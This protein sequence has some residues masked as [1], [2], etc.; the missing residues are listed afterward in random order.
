MKPGVLADNWIRLWQAPSTGSLAKEAVDTDTGK[1]NVKEKGKKGG[2]RAGARRRM[3]LRSMKVS[4]NTRDDGSQ[5]YQ[6]N[7]TTGH[8]FQTSKLLKRINKGSGS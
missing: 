2:K 7:S 8:R 6:P 4:A 5:D 1:C 3:A